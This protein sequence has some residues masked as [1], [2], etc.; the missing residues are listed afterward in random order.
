MRYTE[1]KQGLKAIINE[2]DYEVHLCLLLVNDVEQCKGFGS[3][4]MSELIN[5]SIRNG[6]WLTLIPSALYGSNLRRLKK[7]YRRMGFRKWINHKWRY[8][9]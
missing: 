7:W 4:Y 2:T 1:L 8:E 3:A 9:L 6:K 5:Y